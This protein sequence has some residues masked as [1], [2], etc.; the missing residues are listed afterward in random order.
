[1]ENKEHGQ[2]LFQKVDG[3]AHT[4]SANQIERAKAGANS[5]EN[6]DANDVRHAFETDSDGYYRAVKT[7][8]D[9]LL[10]SYPRDDTLK[11]AFSCSEWVRVKGSKQNPE[12]LVGVVY[13]NGRARYICYALAAQ[14]KNEPPEEIKNVCSFVPLSPFDENKGFFVIFQSAAT[15]ECVKPQK[16]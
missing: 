5:K 7:E 1:M 11:G 9:E 10:R 14:N 2:K 16:A 4:Q 8:I 6:V 13:L 3:D 15:G 12:Y